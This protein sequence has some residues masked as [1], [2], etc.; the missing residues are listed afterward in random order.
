VRRKGACGS[1]I[2]KYD[3]QDDLWRMYELQEKEQS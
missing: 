3:P 2:Q 1:K